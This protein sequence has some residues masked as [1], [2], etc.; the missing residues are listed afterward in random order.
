MACVVLPVIGAAGEAGMVFLRLWALRRRYCPRPVL[1]SGVLIC[2]VYQTLVVA[3]SRFLSCP[4][5][6]GDKPTVAADVR[7]DE[8]LLKQPEPLESAQNQSDEDVAQQNQ[9]E[10][11]G[12]VVLLMG[13]HRAADTEVQLYQRVLQRLGYMVSMARYA[14]TSAT[15][16]QDDGRPGSD[17][18]AVLI[19]LR[20]S[21]KSCLKKM[22][23][24]HLQAH[25]RVNM[26]PTL[27]QAF[28]SA[29]G[30][31]RFQAHS[32][33][34]GLSIPIIPSACGPLN[35][36]L[37]N[38][39]PAATDGWPASGPTPPASRAF[40]AT[41][42]VYV[43]VTSASPLAAFLHTTGLVRPR[44]SAYSQAAQLHTFFLEQL[45]PDTYLQPLESMREA[46]AAVLLS[47]AMSSDDQR[48]AQA[49]CEL[50]YQLL[51]FT[52]RYS[53]SVQPEIVKVQAELHFDDLKDPG[54]DG[55]I[56]KEFILEDTLNFLLST[57]DRSLTSFP[58]CIAAIVREKY[59][60]CEG[61][62]SNCL[63][64]KEKLVLLQF[65]SQL[66]SLGPFDVLYPA[67][68]PALT[69]LQAHL[70]QRFYGE[71]R[72]QKRSRLVALLNQI[73]SLLYTS[74]TLKQPK[75]SSVPEGP[76]NLTNPSQNSQPQKDYLH[77]PDCRHD[78]GK[79]MDPRLRQLYTDP[80]LVLTP[81]FSPEVKEYWAEVPFDVVAL[82]IRAEP[83]SCQCRVHL[84]ERRGP[85][86]AS[87]PIGLGSSRV[88]I[89]L[90]DESESEP[91]VMTIY[92][93][94]VFRESRP[95][96]PIFDEYVTCGFRQD[97]GLVVQPDLPCGLEPLPR[98]S[99]PSRPCLSGD[100]PGRWVVPC[101]SCSDN[102]TCDWRV[103]SWQPDDCYY[104]V[105]EGP[106]L[107][108]CM[109]GRKVLFIGDST[110]RG[111]M[112]YFMERVNGTLEAWDKAHDTIV[113]HNVNDGGTLI[114]YSYYPQFWLDRSQRPTFERAL[115]QL[116][117]RSHPLEN[118]PQTVL[119]VGGVQ[120]LTPNHL[121]IL[122]QVLKR[123][124]LHNILVMVKTIGMGF[125]LPVD[126]IHSLSLRGV[127][128]LH[129]LNQNILT[130][131]KLYG[132]EAIDTLSVTMGRYKEFLQ[133]KCACHFH[134]VGKLAFP[135]RPQHRDTTLYQQAAET[136]LGPSGTLDLQ[137]LG[138][139][140]DSPY[141]VKGAVNQ[142]YSEVLLS[143]MC[144]SRSRNMTAGPR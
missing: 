134:E 30:I 116:I 111:M 24:Y 2:L 62:Y 112:Y 84:D 117:E 59:S 79:C 43:L 4:P 5:H 90:V 136:W 69:S 14:E 107:R 80:P 58:E 47:A 31:C 83:E 124:N 48:P 78:A 96:L 15:L 125:H 110:N 86:K 55:Q 135:S 95:S 114:S 97:C 94:H 120:W 13:Q 3:R 39:D 27:S 28:S 119:V 98:A 42:S 8:P 32:L 64:Y 52:L 17:T 50:C 132:F 99:A 26:I 121:K 118:S 51:T 92:T 49:R 44:I 12:R 100:A 34:S 137:E 11:A 101:L 68:S 73:R 56:L 41:V 82:K 71:E 7:F 18:W 102:R 87:Y 123:E 127:Q 67:A 144:D 91:V 113:Y 66:Q 140:A 85:S 108:D 106:Q 142:V 133:G 19:C 21:E 33:L 37:G 130:T 103:V 46:I 10:W 76:R 115:Q 143:R 22:N 88:S 54:F 9:A 38:L 45:G 72:S 57:R 63:P 61:T 25:Q 131:A 139:R 138:S 126:G 128:E 65:V 75:R 77:R 60:G 23:S 89:L 70:D 93:L 6:R 40:F 109:L 81:P 35:S 20:G 16:R 122:Q 53:G 1:L 104:P 36:P 129:N 141:H 74:E 29:G 105:L